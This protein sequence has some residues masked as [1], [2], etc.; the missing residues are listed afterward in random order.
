MAGERSVIIEVNAFIGGYGNM[1][2]AESFKS[3]AIKL[4]KLTYST[5]VGERSVSYGAVESLDAEAT[6]KA[7]PKALF[8][9]IAKLD[10]AEIIYKKA[11]KTGS[12]TV[13][14]EWVCK[15]AIDIEYGEAKV[16]EF[17]DVKVSQK[18]LKAYTHE[19]N[20]K[21]MVDIDHDNLKVE[22]NGKDL[23]ADARS[24]IQG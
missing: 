1:G 23:L 8:D 4:K 24:I 20:N 15:G 9:E 11:V 3:P 10:N 6:F 5:G 2:T 22:I 21:V 18:G 19:I 12:E 17:L 16:G 14:Y 7:M 13:A